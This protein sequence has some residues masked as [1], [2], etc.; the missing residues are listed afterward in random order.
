MH[1]QTVL[2]L[3][4]GN[5]SRRWSREAG[6]VV[7]AAA[8]ADV[9]VVSAAA[10]AAGTSR[11]PWCFFFFCWTA[12]LAGGAAV[13]LAVTVSVSVV[14]L[15]VRVMVVAAT[16]VGGT[17]GNCTAQYDCA[18]LFAVS[19]RKGWIGAAEQVDAGKA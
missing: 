11:R 15:S 5:D 4:F 19:G 3:D 12:G 2:A 7:S 10:A 18:A 8:G 14:R 9:D 13:A 16:Q 1:L 17:M 6:A